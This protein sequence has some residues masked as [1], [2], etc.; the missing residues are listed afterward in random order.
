MEANPP[1]GP[2]NAKERVGN[3]NVFVT[4][5]S[6]SVAWFPRRCQNAWGPDSIDLQKMFRLI[7]GRAQR[8]IGMTKNLKTT[9]LWAEKHATASWDLA[10]AW[11][12]KA[13]LSVATDQ[14][15]S[16]RSNLLSC[17]CTLDSARLRLLR[18]VW[19]DLNDPLKS[20][21]RFATED[22]PRELGSDNTDQ[23]L[24]LLFCLEHFWLDC[25]FDLR[26]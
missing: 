19:T 7:W 9:T 6:M 26:W 16:G 1:F 23:A 11:V 14:F 8:Q 12:L 10:C 20:G 3:L 15:S 25:A 21:P 17:E 22:R 2:N 18:V 4:L 5:N 13:L 24:G